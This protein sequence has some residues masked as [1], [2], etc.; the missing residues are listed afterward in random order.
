MLCKKKTTFLFDKVLLSVL[1]LSSLLPQIKLLGEP[2]FLLESIRL[3]IVKEYHAKLLGLHNFMSCT[4]N[5]CPS[6][7][8]H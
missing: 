1:V 6:R 7:N 5:L 2:G 3:D 4:L 8:F